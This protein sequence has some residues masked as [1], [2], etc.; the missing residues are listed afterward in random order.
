MTSY[1]F[2]LF[3]DINSSE[4]ANGPQHRSITG[5]SGR[6]RRSWALDR[7]IAVY[8]LKYVCAQPCSVFC[9]SVLSRVPSGKKVY[10]ILLMLGLEQLAYSASSDYLLYPFL[11]KVDVGMEHV[12][13]VRSIVTYIVGFLMFPVMGWIADVWVGQYRMIHFSLWLLW[14]GYAALA[15]LYSACPLDPKGTPLYL[16]PLLFAVISI[17][18]S[19]FQANAIPFGAEVIKY[20]TSQELSSYFHC[21]YW[22]RNFGLTLF[23]IT[24]N[25]RDL[26]EK[27]QEVVYTMVACVCISLALVLNGIF[28][29][30]YD[31]TRERVNPYKKVL[32]VLYLAVV[33]K[34]PVHRSA[35]SFTGAEPPSRIS[36]TKEVHG[37]KFTSAEVEDVKTF[38]RLLGVLLC[39]LFALITY[40]GVSDILAGFIW[41]VIGG[42]FC[43]SIGL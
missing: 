34:R 7:A 14:A 5:C 32:Q 11:Y 37:G 42:L 1:Y 17:G 6:E 31:A 18:H 39:M 43:T 29:R 38:L 40:A 25:C 8:R 12:N 22:M 27:T 23:F 13:L 21:Y 3:Q 26:S 30:W 24:A 20:R 36:L 15:L 10:V 9:R 35:F 33:I 16:L 4:S 2:I 41:R 19:G 28:H